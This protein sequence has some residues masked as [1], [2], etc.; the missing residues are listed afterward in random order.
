MLTD[1][2]VSMLRQYETIAKQLVPFPAK[3]FLRKSNW[4]FLYLKQKL[5]NIVLKKAITEE[6]Y[7]P[8]SG[9]YYDEF[10]P[11]FNEK[12]R[13]VPLRNQ[14]RISPDLGARD[15]LRLQWLYLQNET[16]LFN[17]ET[18]LLHVAPEYCFYHHFKKIKNIKY[19]PV[20][21]CN[22][23]YTRDVGYADLTDL[24]FAANTFDMIICNNVLEHL[25]DDIKALSEM[26]RVLKPGGIAI[27]TVPIDTNRDKTYEDNSIT[28]PKD[29]EREFGQWD[30]IRYYGLDFPDRLK[31]S[32]FIVEKVFYAEKFSNTDFVKFGLINEPIF[33]C[34]KTLS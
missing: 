21:K 16:Q 31:N 20:D 28:A 7:C 29:R 25:M 12:D 24:N 17:Q 34:H 8:I 9:K 18:K 26:Y 19:F 3:L 4:K 6:V 33:V 32:G 22:K 27:I 10:I 30:H 14:A 5:K 13:H 23:K 15:N 1:F 11:L 2:E